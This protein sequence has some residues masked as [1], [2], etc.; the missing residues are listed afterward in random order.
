MQL[1]VDELTEMTEI[2][3]ICDIENQAPAPSISEHV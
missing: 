1:I 3:V 2:E